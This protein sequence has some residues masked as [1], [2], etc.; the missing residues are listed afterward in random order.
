VLCTG[1]AEGALEQQIDKLTKE[2]SLLREA[3]THPAEQTTQ[4]LLAPKHVGG[5]L[6]EKIEQPTFCGGTKYDLSASERARRKP[7][8]GSKGKKYLP[9]PPKLF[10][11]HI[12][13]NLD[14]WDTK[15]KKNLTVEDVVIGIFAGNKVAFG[16][17]LAMKN[18]WLSRF[19]LNYLYS[20]LDND[21]VGVIGLGKRHSFKS[22]HHGS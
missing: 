6:L 2:V 16:R 18:A 21:A 20:G 10:C 14:P 1:K 8:D 19:P 17:G 22:D 4:T 13:D 15:P 9:L 5:A 11:S 12:K 7:V 3:K